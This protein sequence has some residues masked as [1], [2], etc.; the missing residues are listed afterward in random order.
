MQTDQ[1]SLEGEQRAHNSL[2]IHNYWWHIMGTSSSPFKVSSCM[3]SKAICIPR[4]P[5]ILSQS[6]PLP[7]IPESFIQLPPQYQDIWYLKLTRS[8]T[9]FWASFQNLLHLSLSPT[10]DATS[11]SSCPAPDLQHH[12]TQSHHYLLSGLLQCLLSL[13][14]CSYPPHCIF[15]MAAGVTFSNHKWAHITYANQSCNEIPLHPY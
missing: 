14:F 11:S 9:D 1:F 12:T 5:D 8:K 15:K 6:T 2:P 4:T 10:A 13:S 3:P 7:Q